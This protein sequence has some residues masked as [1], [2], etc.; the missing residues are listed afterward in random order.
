VTII[1][2]VISIAALLISL[3][4]LIS[5]LSRSGL[6]RRLEY[7][8][9]RGRIQA[10]ITFQGL[11]LLSMVEE[12]QLIDSTEAHELLRK[13]LRIMEGLTDMRRKLAELESQPAFGT[14][15][16]IGRL[17]TVVSSV[18][19]TEPVF[20]QLRVAMRIPDLPKALRVADGLL[21]RILGDVKR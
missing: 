19:D 10:K 1:S 9:M 14:S 15:L 21:D 13:L 4:N 3:I 7:E 5:S 17:S 12:L 11:E 20:E 8:Q 6:D 2:I 18:D 16:L